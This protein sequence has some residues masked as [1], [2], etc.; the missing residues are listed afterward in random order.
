[1]LV[2]ITIGILMLATC[3]Y[4]IALGR[5]LQS[6][7]AGQVELLATIE[8]FDE[9]SRRAEKNLNAMQGAGASLNGELSVAT[10]K[11]NALIDE[12]SVMVNAGDHIAG[13]IEGAV[14]EVRA[15]GAKSRRLAS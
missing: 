8:R 11:A 10:E 3:G 15:I 4:C 13:R 5:K 1:M 2:E 7:R 12:L 14:R 9:A 6:L